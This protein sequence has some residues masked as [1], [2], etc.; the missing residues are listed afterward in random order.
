MNIKWTY[1]NYIHELHVFYNDSHALFI[2]HRHI[3]VILCRGLMPCCHEQ[4]VRGLRKE[5]FY[6]QVWLVNYLDEIQLK[7]SCQPVQLVR[8]ILYLRRGFHS[9]PGTF[10]CHGT[11]ISI[12]SCGLEIQNCRVQSSGARSVH[13]RW[14]FWGDFPPKMTFFFRYFFEVADFSDIFSATNITWPCN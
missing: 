10:Q 12:R 1:L 2:V 8:W 6:I 9:T 11:S 4:L 13:R 5:A 7:K 14:F 3:A